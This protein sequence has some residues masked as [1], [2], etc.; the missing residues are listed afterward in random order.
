MADQDIL[1]PD[2]LADSK[3]YRRFYCIDLDELEDMELT[4]EI[5]YL[6]PK[7]WGLPKVNWARERVWLLEEEMKKRRGNTDFRIQQKPK[8]VE[9]IRV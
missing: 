7:L 9:G 8:K 5:N 1:I 3:Q 2:P 6:R 4:D